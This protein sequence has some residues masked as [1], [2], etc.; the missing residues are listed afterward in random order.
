MGWWTHGTLINSVVETAGFQFGEDFGEE[1]RLGIDAQH[2]GA[3]AIQQQQASDKKDNGLVD[4][5]WFS[6]S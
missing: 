2:A 4:L 3:Q 6:K 1:A 5:C